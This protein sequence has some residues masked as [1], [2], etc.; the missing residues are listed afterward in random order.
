MA[1]PSAPDI[2]HN[3]ANLD[4]GDFK[5]N[6]EL[7]ELAIPPLELDPQFFSS[8]E[9]MATV[10]YE[11]FMSD[12]GFGFGFNDNCDFELTFDDL[13]NLYLPSEGDDFLIPDGLD[14]GDTLVVHHIQQPSGMNASTYSDSPVYNTH[15]PCRHM[16]APNPTSATNNLGWHVNTMHSPN[17]T[18]EI[19]P[20]TEKIGIKAIINL[21]VSGSAAGL[22][23]ED[24]ESFTQTKAAPTTELLCY[25]G[26]TTSPTLSKTLSLLSSTFQ[27]PK[28]LSSPIPRA[29]S[30]SLHSCLPSLPRFLSR[31]ST[32]D[33][34]I[35]ITD[36]QEEDG[37]E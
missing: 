13:D 31:L 27:I 4:H 16:D 21:D 8:D 6:A 29:P 17:A 5:F 2:D 11:T 9:G 37:E 12:L 18:A 22:D 10:L 23:D 15:S 32:K 28:S 7:D 30:L 24:E 35:S 1:L 34:N 14:P 26:I 20:D 19:R 3:W 36:D 33:F 25:R